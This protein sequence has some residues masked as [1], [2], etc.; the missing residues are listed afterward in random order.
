M[1]NRR[2]FSELP[3]EK[4]IFLKLQSSQTIEELLSDTGNARS[5]NW[6]LS[7]LDVFVLLVMLIISL[8]AISDLKIGANTPET[9]PAKTRAITPPR[10]R[11]PPESAPRPTQSVTPVE[12]EPEVAVPAAP[13][14][15][16][17]PELKPEPEAEPNP[18]SAPVAPVA[19]TTTTPLVKPLPEPAG[20]VPIARLEP[21]STGETNEAIEPPPA[22]PQEETEPSRLEQ[23]KLGLRQHLDQL[24]LDETIAIKITEDY[25]QLEIQDKIL[26]ESSQAALTESGRA[27][28]LKLAPLLE[29]TTGLIFI[30][31]HTDNRPIHTRQFPSN[32]ELGSARATSVLHYLSTLGLNNSRMR[33]VT[34]ADTMPVADNSTAAGREKNR[35]V[36]ILIQVREPDKEAR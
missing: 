9:A 34:Y 23:M 20:E 30:E 18:E 31:G 25:A 2:P 28:L 10:P 3:K 21:D 15:V 16:I 6:L 32:W 4:N 11:R 36:S 17:K 27:L 19:P 26:F 14:T 12:P 24:G 8:L 22:P 1:T 35:R 33:A 29:Q 5:Q 7:Y 13:T